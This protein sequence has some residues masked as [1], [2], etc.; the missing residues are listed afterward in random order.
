M[1]VLEGSP[2]SGPVATAPGATRPG[3]AT[4]AAVPYGFKL[5][6][7]PAKPG[8][9]PDRTGLGAGTGGRVGPWGR[10]VGASHG[11]PQ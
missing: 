2:P 10:V 1:S 11:C 9:V 3:F 8:P 4:V 7:A 6:L 5:G